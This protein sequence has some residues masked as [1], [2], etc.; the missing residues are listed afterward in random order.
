MKAKFLQRLLLLCALICVCV[1]FAGCEPN[2]PAGNETD[3]PTLGNNNRTNAP[4][5]GN[6]TSE[7]TNERTPNASPNEGVGAGAGVG[8]GTN[9]D[10]TG[11]AGGTGNAGTGTGTGSGTGAGTG[12]GTG[13]AG[14]TPSA[15]ADFNGYGEITASENQMPLSLNSAFI[16]LNSGNSGYLPNAL[17][18]WGVG[19]RLENNQPFDAVDAN[20]KFGKYNAVFIGENEKR[21]Y[22]TFDEGYENGRSAEILDTL[23][24][25][26]V[27]AVFF[28]T[29]DFCVSNKKL[30]MRMLGDGHIV[31]NH[32]TTHPSLPACSDEQ[33]REEIGKLH[34]YVKN[35]FGYDM[36]LIRF[37]RGEFSERTLDIA[38]SMGYKSVFWSFAYKDW[39]VDEQPENGYALARIKEGTHPGE[40]VLLHAVSRTNAS[41]LGSAID[42]WHSNGYKLSLI[43]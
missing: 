16:S 8:A 14:G 4:G 31:G 27:K 29:Y 21:I 26:G 19:R 38:K 6:G 33:V 41:I 20:R 9:A 39:L 10:T 11:G 34:D 32:S 24:E 3:T 42:Y 18:R 13:A 43:D 22:L 1:L 12:T 17:I 36:K 15:A 40:I 5:T 23:R 30:V 37:P 7:R 35:N 2:V 25:K 28:V